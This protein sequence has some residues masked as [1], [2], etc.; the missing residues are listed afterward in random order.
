MKGDYHRPKIDN[1]SV[2]AIAEIGNA[3]SI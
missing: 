1:W 3:I 2:I